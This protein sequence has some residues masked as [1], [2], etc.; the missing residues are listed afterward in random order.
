MIDYSFV[1]PGCGKKIIIPMRIS[2]YSAEGHLCD[3]GTELIRDPEGFHATY[4]VNCDGFYSDH[5]SGD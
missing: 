4:R 2:E 5:P 3:C 1:C